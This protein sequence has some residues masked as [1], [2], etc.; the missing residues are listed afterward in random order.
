MRRAVLAAAFPSLG[1]GFLGVAF[2]FG[3]TVLTMAYAVGPISGAHFN[4]A[5]TLGLLVGRRSP[6]AT[7]CRISSRRC[8]GDRARRSCCAIIATGK[9]G[10]ETGGFAS[11]GYGDQSPGRTSLYACFVI[12]VV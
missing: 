12:E 2:A 8:R 1:I 9:P 10:F 3:L 7:W 4:P 11:N 5:V 6:A